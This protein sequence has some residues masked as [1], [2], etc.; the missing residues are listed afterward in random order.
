M[1]LASPTDLCRELNLEP[2]LAQ[3]ALMERLASS[4][5]LAD[6]RLGWPD[7]KGDVLRAAAMVVLWRVLRDQGVRG[8]VL[9]PAEAWD[10]LRC[11]ELGRLTMSYL[12]QTCHRHSALRD[13]LRWPEWNRLEAGS[14][15]GW[16]VRLVPNKPFIAAEAARRSRIGL[17]LDAGCGQSDFEAS[18][19]A[20]EDAFDLENG[21]LIRLW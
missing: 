5:G 3:L 10:R 19:K 15:A 11:G 18:Q 21:L 17:I 7:D 6:A 8:T 9:A 14:V 13:S 16:E 12:G 2:T 1:L 20:F 4:R